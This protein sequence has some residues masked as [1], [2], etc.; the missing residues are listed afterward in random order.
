VKDIGNYYGDTRLLLQASTWGRSPGS[1]EP[2]YH[3]NFRE[4]SREHANVN[5]IL[6]MGHIFLFH[7]LSFLIYFDQHFVDKEKKYD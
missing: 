3:A 7:V 5:Q 1:T 6:H 4:Q 2:L